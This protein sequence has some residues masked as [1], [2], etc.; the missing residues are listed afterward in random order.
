MKLVNG[1]I[2]NHG[3]NSQFCTSWAPLHDPQPHWRTPYQEHLK[4]LPH[5]LETHPHSK[6]HHPQP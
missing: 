3:Y 6:A 5:F 1:N 4:D 2:Q